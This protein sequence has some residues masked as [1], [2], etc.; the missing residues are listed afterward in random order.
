MDQTETIL[1]LPTSEALQKFNV[2]VKKHQK[3]DNFQF[4]E[5]GT[6]GE[7]NLKIVKFFTNIHQMF[8]YSTLK[9]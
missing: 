1:H 9:Y 3:D 7:P 4:V 8:K 5:F 2:L 6:C